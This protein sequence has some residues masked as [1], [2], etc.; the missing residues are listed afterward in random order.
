[1]KIA[2]NTK[3]FILED[4]SFMRDLLVRKFSADGAIVKFSDH[5]DGTFEMIKEMMPDITILDIMIP[6]Q[7]DGLEVLRK[8]RFDPTTRELKAVVLS[9]LSEKS[10]IDKAGKLGIAA[11]IVKS[12]VTVESIAT[13]VAKQT[14]K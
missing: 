7:I 4:D 11:F 14:Q 8:M 3:I 5:G 9:N 2:K 12:T 6:G 13:E 10:I 1:M